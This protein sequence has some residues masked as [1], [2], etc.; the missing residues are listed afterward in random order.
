M[1]NFRK[2]LGIALSIFIT[3]AS[4]SFYANLKTFFSDSMEGRSPVFFLN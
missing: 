2:M 1:D 4:P 3:E